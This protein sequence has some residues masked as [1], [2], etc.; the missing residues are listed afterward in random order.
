M[1]WSALQITGTTLLAIA[2]AVALIL[3][4]I[5]SARD[6]LAPHK[7]K[8]RDIHQ[9]IDI[10]EARLNEGTKRMNELEDGQRILLLCTLAQMEHS[11]TGNSVEKLKARKDELFAYLVQKGE[12]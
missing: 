3:G 11:I 10:H 5:K 2:G 1:E 4:L 7:K 6:L 8:E 9:T 12:I